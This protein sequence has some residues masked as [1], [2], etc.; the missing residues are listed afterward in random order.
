[1]K[2]YSVI[3]NVEKTCAPE[4]RVILST[5]N[6]YKNYWKRVKSY[7]K[8]GKKG[9]KRSKNWKITLLRFKLLYSAPISEKLFLSI[10]FAKKC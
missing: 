7:L 8:N 2:L 9:W 10:I 3:E 4:F 1:M 6:T 5:T